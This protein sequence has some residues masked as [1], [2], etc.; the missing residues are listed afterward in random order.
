MLRH[1]LGI[2]LPRQILL[3]HKMILCFRREAEFCIEGICYDE[4][5]DAASRNL[6]PVRHR[7]RSSVALR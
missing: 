3:I 2:G 4:S 1:D 5:V 7:R 6:L